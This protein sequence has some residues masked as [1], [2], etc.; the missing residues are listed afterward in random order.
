MVGTKRVD[1]NGKAYIDRSWS[2]AAQGSVG[3]NQGSTCTFILKACEQR[4]LADEAWKFL[5][6]YTSDD[7]RV[8]FALKIEMRM[9][10]ASRYTPANYKAMERLPWTD[11][12][13][14]MLLSQWDNMVLFP[15]IPGSYY[16][17][18]NLTYAF[19]KV[20][21][22]NENPVYA[23]NKYNVIINNELKRKLGSI[24]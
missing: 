5:K 22:N 13:R 1:E 4:G 15:E 11:A 10:V 18:R 14:E 23:L 3:L 9:G 7:V 17:G 16:V 6:W 21:Y 19:R 24:A 12:E 8:E 20:V 2:S